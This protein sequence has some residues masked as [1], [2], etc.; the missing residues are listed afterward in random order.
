[1]TEL[2]L[3]SGAG[4]RELNTVRKHLEVLKGGRLAALAEPAAITA[5]ILSDVVGDPLDV[6]ASGP[7]SPDPTTFE[8]AIDVLRSRGIWSAVPESV[9]AHLLRGRKAAVPETPKP[10]DPTFR[11]VCTRIVGNAAL[12]A[13]RAA[14][15]A[16]QLG[17]RAFVDST[18]VTGEARQVGESI[19]E[20]VLSLLRS[21]EAVCAVWAGETTVTVRGDGRGGRNQE[22]VLSSALRLDGHDGVL[23]FSAGTDGIDGPTD[24]AGALA[25]GSTVARA[26]RL[27][28]EPEEHLERNDSYPL[29]DALGDLV[30]TGPTGTNVMDL[31]LALAAGAP[32][33]PPQ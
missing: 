9:R 7:V 5:L 21:G 16:E 12:A 25:T 20:R 18:V 22:L 24:A 23:V 13:L 29:F 11:G 15:K 31:M 26:R 1:M 19:A 2:L 14:E 10:G 30:K 27:R 32:S 33:S 3:R 17:Y 8:D 28:F 4:I 6:I